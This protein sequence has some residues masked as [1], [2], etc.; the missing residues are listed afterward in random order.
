MNAFPRRAVTAATVAAALTVLLTGCGDADSTDAMGPDSHAQPAAPSTA[1]SLA[2]SMAP[3]SGPA[4]STVKVGLFEWS[5]VTAP[6]RV[7]PGRVRLVVTNTGGTEHDLDVQ[8][9]D[10]HWESP[11]LDPGQRATMIVR[12][13][14]GETL[15]LWCSEPGHRAQGMHTLLHVAG[16]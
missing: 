12:A 15:Q 6:R 16:K 11:T 4:G 3:S 2:P 13:E 9:R 7:E 14:P 5:I 10:G 8:G 1:P